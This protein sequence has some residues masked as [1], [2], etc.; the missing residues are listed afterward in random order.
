MLVSLAITISTYGALYFQQIRISLSR[1]PQNLQD[2]SKDGVAR[3]I[4]RFSLFFVYYTKQ[5]LFWLLTPTALAL[6]LWLVFI[7]VWSIGIWAIVKKSGLADKEMIYVAVG[8]SLGLPYI[9]LFLYAVLTYPRWR[10]LISA[11]LVVIC[12]SIGVG[13]WALM[14]Y[15]P[16]L[17]EEKVALAVGMA[18]GLPCLGLTWLAVYL[19]PSFRIKVDVK[20]LLAQL[21]VL[22]AILSGIVAGTHLIR[23]TKI[24]LCLA[25]GL[26]VPSLSGVYHI[27]IP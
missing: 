23:A 26:G 24:S 8:F 6:L 16:L 4:N 3:Q 17:H 21:L 9:A 2:L 15:A 27:Y 5:S 13:I 10:N 20:L 18:V 19:D 25:L 7:A 12:I 11:S 1:N 14:S 22:T